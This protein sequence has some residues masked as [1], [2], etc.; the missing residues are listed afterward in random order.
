MRAEIHKMKIRIIGNPVAG[1]ARAAGTVERLTAALQRRG[2]DA[3][4]F[5]TRAAGDARREAARAGSAGYDLIVAAGG[6]G[7]LNE[8]L[9]GL[10]HPD[11]TP[12]AVYPVGTAN[13][14]A[15]ETGIPRELDRAVE[16]FVNGKALNADLAIARNGSG[17]ERRFVAVAGVGFDAMVS[18]EV[19]RSRRHRL[20]F[21]GYLG[22]V[23][24]TLRGYDAPRLRVSVDGRVLP[25]ASFAVVANTRNY[26]GLFSLCPRALLTDGRLDV[27]AWRPRS[28]FSLAILFATAFLKLTHRLPGAESCSGREIRIDCDHPVPIQIDGDAFGTTPLSVRLD[29]R[30]VRLL[31]AAASNGNVRLK[32]G[33][34]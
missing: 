24:R 10:E 20:G 23:W 3:S 15:R 11:R 16:T 9:N 18:E 19:T 28:I 26:G 34:S 13:L 22:P 27:L 21:R 17:E 32:R 4:A 25:E 30:G 1:G 29:P 6:D 5:L 33:T 2:A 8:V 7:T 14:V 12:L 31:H